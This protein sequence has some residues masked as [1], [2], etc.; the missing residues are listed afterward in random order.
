LCIT[1]K[2]HPILNIFE[3]FGASS[4]DFDKKHIAT[5]KLQA[6]HQRSHLAFV[7]VFEFKQLAC[8]I[9]WDKVMFMSQFQFGFHGDV[10]ASC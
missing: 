7:Y 6:L 3:N 8:D 5:S 9:S 4:S 10:K 2:L 1:T